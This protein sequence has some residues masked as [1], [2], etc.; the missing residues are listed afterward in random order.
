MQFVGGQ[1]VIEGVMIKSPEK[2][3]IACRTPEGN[4][5]VNQYKHKSITK[6]HKILD[7]PLLRGPIVLVE[8]TILGIKALNYSADVAVEED[9][10]PKAGTSTLS[11]IFMLLFSVAFALILFKLIPLAVAQFAAN[12]NGTFENRYLFNLTEGATKILLLV[13]YIYGISFM[14]DVRRVFHYHGAEHKVVNAWEKNDLDNVKKYSTIHVRCGTSFILFVLGLSII[15]Y[16]FLPTDI[17]FWTKYGL[18]IALLPIIAG[19]GYEL[20][21]MSPKYEKNPLFRLII[22]PGLLLQKLTTREPDDEQLE[23]AKAALSGA[24]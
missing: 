23:V 8:T 14:P 20:I 9:H 15:V 5:I 21:R 12:Y 13:G 2:V 11:M 22:S 10:K 3:A 16:L 19:I 7:I 24:L 6:K 17:S 1:A 18:R 4:I